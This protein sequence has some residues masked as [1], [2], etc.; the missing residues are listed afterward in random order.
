MTRFARS[1]EV[2]APGCDVSSIAVLATHASRMDWPG[3]YVWVPLPVKVV[4]SAL[5]PLGI[6]TCQPSGSP[7]NAAPSMSPC[8]W[9][10]G[11]R[12]TG[13]LGHRR[14][15]GGDSGSQ[16]SPRRQ[17][18]RN[19]TQTPGRAYMRESPASPRQGRCRIRR[20]CRKRCRKAPGC[21][22]VGDDAVCVSGSA[23]VAE[24][25][26]G[27]SI[28]M[29][30][31]RPPCHRQQRSTAV[32][33]GRCDPRLIRSAGRAPDSRVVPVLPDDDGPV[34]VHGVGLK[35]TK[36]TTELSRLH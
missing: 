18:R 33:V 19:C 31:N 35:R 29:L 3:A 11:P 5:T 28:E 30:G 12:S 14:G 16:H 13:S 26:R 2:R 32:G 22:P 10:R 4:P 23:L 1:T 27:R 20:G 17:N 7:P 9:P 21:G 34:K 24:H 15:P 8:P 6:S 36:R 25:P